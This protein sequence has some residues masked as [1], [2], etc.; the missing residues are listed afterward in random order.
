[1]GKRLGLRQLIGLRLFERLHKR[2]VEEHRLRTLFWECTLRC[3]L[4]CRH[5]GSDCRQEALAP[6][7][8]SEDFFRVLDTQITPHVDPHKVLIILSG[9]EVLVRR[10]LEHI[11][12]ELYRR[13]YPW[14]M[15]TNGLA[16]T[17]ERL[18]SLI[19]S[20]LHSI[21]VSLD[22]FEPQH[23][24]IRGNRES[25]ARAVEAI[26]MISADKELASDVVTCAT[27]ALMPRLD[28]FKEF[29]LGLGV[30]RWRLFS[31]FPVGR[32]AEDRTL[33]LSDE[34]FTALMRFIE[35]TRKEGRIDLSYGCEGFLAGYE[36]RV[37]DGFFECYA[38]VSTASIR[39]DGD[40]S[41]CTSIRS[42]FAQGNIYRDD[43]WQVWQERFGEFRR[44]EWAHKDR[45]AG[46]D[47][48]RYCQGN[49]MHLYDD[50]RR[51]MFCHMHRLVK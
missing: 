15:V 9:G 41:G 8:P 35:R 38:G 18:D 24:H 13:Q 27:P 6:D 28:E 7:M 17:R 3:N 47:M 4:Q 29:L 25:F 23:T 51:L 26:R 49:G 5:C 33:Q 14:G 37:R 30:R 46:C 43:F 32:A 31:I 39:I 42:S 40:I 22:G 10:D 45:C 2:R 48:W 12:L 16:L 1:M 44:R 50:D 36:A 21:T 19:R 20:G 11:G 34:E